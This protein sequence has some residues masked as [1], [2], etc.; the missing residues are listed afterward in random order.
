MASSLYNKLYEINQVKTQKITASNLK[1]GVN[2]FGINGTFTSNTNAL[3]SDIANGKTAYVNGSK[4]TGTLKEYN[5]LTDEIPFYTH[6]VNNIS[7]V[8]TSHYYNNINIVVNSSNVRV[9]DGVIRNQAYMNIGF[10]TISS[11][12]NIQPVDIKKG[13]KILDIEGQYDASTEFSGIKMDPVVE[14]DTSVG[15]A[16]SIRE[17][18]G[19]DMANGTNLSYYFSNLYGLTLVS[20]INTPKVTNLFRLFY[21][22]Y[23]LKTF[24]AV[25]M[26]GEEQTGVSCYE[27]F[28]YCR[29]LE[30]FNNVVFPKVISSCNSMFNQCSNIT[31]IT[32]TLNISGLTAV[33]PMFNN[34]TNLVNVTN[35]MFN[36]T[37]NLNLYY[38]FVG[39][40]NLNVLGV[41]FDNIRV[42]VSTSMFNGV[43]SIN[44]SSIYTLLN[45]FNLFVVGSSTF[46]NTSLTKIP[47][48]ANTNSDVRISV[49]TPWLFSRCHNITSID[50]TEHLLHQFTNVQG[51]FQGCSNLQSFNGRV[52]NNGMMAQ[53][54]SSCS[55][56]ETVNIGNVY[57]FS[58]N[59]SEMFYNCNNLVSVNFLNDV[60]YIGNANSMFR[61]C[62]N[63]TDLNL[64]VNSIYNGTFMFQN[65]K[66]LKRVNIRNNINGYLYGMFQ[67]CYNL[68]SI[69]INT[70]SG[71]GINSITCLFANCYNL[72]GD[73]TLEIN[74]TSFSNDLQY[75][76]YNTGLS[77]INAN[78][79]F[80]Y[81]G[82]YYGVNMNYFIAFCNNL[83][84]INVNINDRLR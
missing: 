30:G 49:N 83:K 16:T 65:C 31:D 22:S 35:I 42:S 5:N 1:T 61:L 72:V 84:T 64:N 79:G 71:S 73:M 59:L 21:Q 75:V 29:N 37:A 82:S 41:P 44:D 14:S 46:A 13:A 34:C 6:S 25:N 12:L 43:K 81:T 63:L 48:F 8:I 32:S 55:T 60:N 56:L 2:A 33:P 3:S 69:G 15:L 40:Y 77:N 80:K 78:I 26:Y 76:F 19:L 47:N 36:N 38:L 66:N 62:E 70:I 57:S 67:N 17:I 18:S 20:N 53:M 51:L 10:N 4:V 58:M 11:L 74:N 28:N 9:G 7:S 24:T 23:N 39:C 27:M 45:K 68:S 52:N 50:D 54:F